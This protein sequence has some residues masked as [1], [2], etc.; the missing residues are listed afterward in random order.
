MHAGLSA[1]VLC[2]LGPGPGALMK[3]EVVHCIKRIAHGIKRSNDTRITMAVKL[4]RM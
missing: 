3:V 2:P 4:Y 1:A